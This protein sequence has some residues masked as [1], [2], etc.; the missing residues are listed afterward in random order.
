MKTTDVEHIERLL[1]AKT[2]G[3]LSASEKELVS[4]HVSGEEEYEAMRNTLLRVKHVFQAEAQALQPDLDL[5]EQV[6]LRFAQNKPAAKSSGSSLLIFLESLLLPPTFRF[7]GALILILALGITGMLLLNN[8]QKNIALNGDTPSPVELKEEEIKSIEELSPVR[9]A[10][11][12][13]EQPEVNDRTAPPLPG[14]PVTEAHTVFAEET[15]TVMEAKDADVMKEAPA[16]TASESRATDYRNEGGYSRHAH[17]RTVREEKNRKEKA[18]ETTADMAKKAEQDK[19]GAEKKLPSEPFK[20]E[21]QMHSEPEVYGNGAGSSALRTRIPFWPPMNPEENTAV[22]Y[23]K[24][25][26]KLEAY[27]STAQKNDTYEEIAPKKRITL[28]LSFSDEGEVK[29]AEVISGNLSE[30]EKAFITEKAMKLPRF[31]FSQGNGEIQKTQTY[32]IRI[33]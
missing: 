28:K 30:E 17:T 8:P 11:T 1:Q 10:V 22:L 16:A 14:K 12:G 3:E 7:A 18:P 13:E 29:K 20:Q 15:E 24:T 27:F 25:G 23:R 21:G 31:E 32:K 33:R 5:K 19:I 9:Q 6:L 4:A 26:E 2:F